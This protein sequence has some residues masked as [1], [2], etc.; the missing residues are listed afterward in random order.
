[1][2]SGWSRNAIE[3]RVAHGPGPTPNG[4]EGDWGTPPGPRYG[5]A[6][7]FTAALGP[8]FRTSGGQTSNRVTLGA[9]DIDFSGGIAT[10]HLE[11]VRR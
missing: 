9:F 5:A 4:V 1:M 8:D 3:H 10:S 6:A 7:P 11:I 2:G